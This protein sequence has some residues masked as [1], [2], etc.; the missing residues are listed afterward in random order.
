M[1]DRFSG[2]VSLLVSS[3]IRVGGE[4]MDAEKIDV[5]LVLVDHVFLRD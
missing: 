1:G 5:D 4:T 3:G 2:A